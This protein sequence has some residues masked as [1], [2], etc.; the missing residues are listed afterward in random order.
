MAIEPFMMLYVQA[1]FPF[2]Q[3]ELQF[4]KTLHLSWSI[5]SHLV[6]ILFLVR[7]N[8]EEGQNQHRHQHQLCILRHIRFWD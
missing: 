1:H 6:D 4:L 3:F 2:D 8:Q 7:H 5:I